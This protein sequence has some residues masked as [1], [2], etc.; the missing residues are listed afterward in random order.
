[1]SLIVYCKMLV[2]YS[3][4]YQCVHLYLNSLFALTVL[5]SNVREF[6]AA[7]PAVPLIQCQRDQ[8]ETLP[9]NGQ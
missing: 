8:L 7:R 5:T 3:Y 2:L 4:V 9:K 6:S 1:M